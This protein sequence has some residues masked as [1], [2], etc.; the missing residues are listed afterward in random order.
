MSYNLGS[1]SPIEPLSL[2]NVI[3]AGIRIYRSHLKD[4]FC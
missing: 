4:Y 2:G 1:P 3:T